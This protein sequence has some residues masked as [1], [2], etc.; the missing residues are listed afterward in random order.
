MVTSMSRGMDISVVSPLASRWATIV[1]SL[2]CPVTRA[3]PP[4]WLPVPARLSV[5][6]SSQF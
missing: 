3:V 2:R 1:V 5:P 6:T 4:Y